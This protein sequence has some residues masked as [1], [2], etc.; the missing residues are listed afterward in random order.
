MTIQCVTEGKTVKFTS[1]NITQY[2][3]GNTSDLNESKIEDNGVGAHWFESKFGINNTI[4]VREFHQGNENNDSWNS[5]IWVH[6]D[7]VNSINITVFGY[8]V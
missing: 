6:S 2:N 8:A 7:A 5:D 4:Y 3:S 1:S